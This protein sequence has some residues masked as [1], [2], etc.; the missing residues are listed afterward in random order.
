MKDKVKEIKEQCDIWKDAVQKHPYSDSWSTIQM[1]QLIAMLTGY[2][3]QLEDRIEVLERDKR[4]T[5]MYKSVG[6]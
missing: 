3:S 2:I 6:L 4:N 5:D 1:V